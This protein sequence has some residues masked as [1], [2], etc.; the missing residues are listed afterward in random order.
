MILTPYGF[1]AGLGVFV[2]L[3]LLP[4]LKYEYLIIC[5]LAIILQSYLCIDCKNLYS[6]ASY[7]SILPILLLLTNSFI[8]I[9]AG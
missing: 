9:N 7:L 3:N 5:M 4:V 2:S 8:L 6:L 1:F